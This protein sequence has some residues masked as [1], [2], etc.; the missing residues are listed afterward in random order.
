VVGV[1]LAWASCLGAATVWPRWNRVQT[2]DVQL[3]ERA[4]QVT[5]LQGRLD[6]ARLAAGKDTV[7]RARDRVL[8]RHE[9]PAFL[10][11]VRA[12]ACAAGAKVVALDQS[13]SAARPGV[14]APVVVRGRLVAEGRFKSLFEILRYLENRR[15]FVAVDRAELVPLSADG[16]L[17]AVYRFQFLAVPAAP[18]AE[19]EA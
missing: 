16:R 8:S 2:L 12:R 14:S 10:R 15:V 11:E 9:V 3:Q 4:A 19:E 7:S 17:K 5:E 13:E 6:A 1:C 18:A